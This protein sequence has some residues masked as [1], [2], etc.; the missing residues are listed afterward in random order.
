[1]LKKV[2][3]NTAACHCCKNVQVTG[4]CILW[5]RLIYY[6]ENERYKCVI[7][8]YNYRVIFTYKNRFYFYT[9]NHHNNYITNVILASETV[10]IRKP[11]ESHL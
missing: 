7:F 3:E 11:L 9:V 1:M 8:S 5:K 4:T 6:R 10:E 2:E